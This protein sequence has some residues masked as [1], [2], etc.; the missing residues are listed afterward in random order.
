[1]YGTIETNGNHTKIN[2][3]EN[4]LQAL[5]LFSGTIKPSYGGLWSVAC[6]AFN[7]SYKPGKGWSDV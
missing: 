3:Q 1:M 4:S 6:I 7:G 2:K 5:I